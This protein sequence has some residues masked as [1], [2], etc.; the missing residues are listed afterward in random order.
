MHTIPQ[1]INTIPRVPLIISLAIGLS[2]IGMTDMAQASPHYGAE[3]SYCHSADQPGALTLTGETGI[4]NELKVFEV[5]PGG[6]VDIG[7]NVS[8]PGM[9][10]FYRTVVRGLDRLNGVDPENGTPQ[11]FSLLYTPDPTWQEKSPSGVQYLFWEGQYYG[12]S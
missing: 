9:P 4:S 7:I 11:Y 10:T 6:Q 1:P 3:C 8:N 12:H 5:E 2:V